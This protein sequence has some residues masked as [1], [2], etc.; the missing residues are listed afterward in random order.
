ME[1]NLCRLC[2]KVRN[3]TNLL[4]LSVEIV[5][6]VSYYCRVDLVDDKNLSQK[7]CFDCNYAIV[8][9]AKF[10]ENVKDVQIQCL[11][12]NDF[13]NAPVKDEQEEIIDTVIEIL[14]ESADDK[15]KSR[16]SEPLPT[17]VYVE[18]Q[19]IEQDN[20]EEED[21]EQSCSDWDRS[22][23]PSDSEFEAPLS[24]RRGTRQTKRSEEKPKKEKIQ[25]IHPSEV[26]TISDECILDVPASDKHVDGSLAE[27]A[28][29][30]FPN[31]WCKIRLSC[32]E[33]GE[34]TDG[35]HL[36]KNHYIRLHSDLQ[37]DDEKYQCTECDGEESIVTYF[38]EYLNHAVAHQPHLKFC[39]IICSKM[40]CNTYALY[41]HYQKSHEQSER[42]SI[43]SC[44]VCCQFF[45]DVDNLEAHEQEIHKI[46]VQR[47]E[48]ESKTQCQSI[49]ETLFAKE[50]AS[51]FVEHQNTFEVS[52][53]EKNIDGTVTDSCIRKFA[54]Q[55]WSDIAV[56]C[57]ECAEILPSPFL[58][59]EHYSV[60]HA[61]AKTR[62][63]ICN[64]CPEIKT[65]FNFESFINHVFTIHYEHLR[66][67]CF[68]CDSMFWNYK[69]LYNHFGIFHYE[70]RVLMCIHCGKY[71]KSGYDLKCHKEIHGPKRE[72][73]EINSGPFE[74]S[75]CQKAFSKAHQLRRHL[76]AHKNVKT[77]I[78]ETCGKS[79]SAKATLI[80]HRYD[81]AS[82]LLLTVL[83]I[84][85]V[86]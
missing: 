53:N 18:E 52:E 86:P 28:Y 60:K 2:G 74:C 11:I 68:V 30:K 49:V 62:N 71:H 14:P 55:L 83:S 26:I 39:C 31:L 5:F 85:N 25:K 77:W 40:F 81:N 16:S 1:R 36:L 4:D 22:A 15:H 84:N 76:E 29:S 58:L 48:I 32:M 65:F 47:E 50:L 59:S 8:N 80:N 19:I 23:E 21:F 43:H 82:L 67:I 72:T 63:Y 37:D 46:Q 57:A 56:P 75:Q 61:D 33:C 17:T 12:G 27:T 3:A 78:C 9:F 70:V 6:Q 7:I 20:E 51:D 24:K 73:I 66:Y 44:L 38:Y 64:S 69:S 42:I 54:G 10:S 13:I 41:H 35:P 79:F 45:Q 34:D